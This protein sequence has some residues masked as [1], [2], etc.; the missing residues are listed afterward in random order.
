MFCSQ[1][2]GQ[3]IRSIWSSV[4]I[5][6]ISFENKMEEKNAYIGKSKL[7]KE[8]KLYIVYLFGFVSVKSKTNGNFAANQL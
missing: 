4:A 7:F 6:V 2:C 5:V 8:L 3:G 1:L